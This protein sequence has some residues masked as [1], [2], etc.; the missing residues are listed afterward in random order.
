MSPNCKQKGHSYLLFPC[1]VHSPQFVS[2]SK[3][4]KAHLGS[5]FLPL[6]NGEMEET[7]KTHTNP[8]NSNKRN[9]GYSLMEIYLH[10]KFF[11]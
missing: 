9:K 10:S 6:A 4:K 8:R 11:F 2:T 1:S 3:H 5:H 7:E